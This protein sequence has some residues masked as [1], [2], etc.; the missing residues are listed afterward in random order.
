V[1]RHRLG[2]L[3]ARGVGKPAL[4]DALATGGLALF[5]WE[6]LRAAHHQR[7]VFDEGVYLLKGLLFARH[8]YTPFQPNGPWT[9]H[10]PL[11]FL[12]PGYLQKWLGPGLTTGRYTTIVM[13]VLVLTGMWWLVRQIA[14][15][16]WAA[17]AV[18]AVVVMPAAARVYSMA[19]SEALAAMF[20]IWAVALL[21]TPQ[22]SRWRL[23]ISGLLAGILTMT[24]V[25]M[26]AAWLVLGL[27]AIWQ[28]RRRSLWFWIPSLVVVLGLH[29]LYWPRIMWLWAR[30]LPDFVPVPAAF[31]PPLHDTAATYR[32]SPAIWARVRAL[33]QAVQAFPLAWAG[34]WVGTTAVFVAQKRNNFHYRFLMMGT[35]L[36]WLLVLL[37]GWASIG[38]SYCVNCLTFYTGFYMP[39]LVAL[40][41]IGL[42][43]PW[44]PERTKEAGLFWL[45]GLIF[46]VSAALVNISIFITTVSRA[47]ASHHWLS[48]RLLALLY[49]PQIHFFPDLPPMDAG[50]VFWGLVLLI[51]S[52]IVVSVMWFLRRPRRLFAPGQKTV[53]LASLVILA[54]LSPL[55]LFSGSWTPYDCS[56]DV[57]AVHEDTAVALAQLLPPGTQVYWASYFGTLLLRTEDIILMPQ[58]LNDDYN[59]RQGGDADAL[60]SWGYWNQALAEQWMRSAD[61]IVTDAM[62][63]ERLPLDYRALGFEPVQTFSFLA[64]CAGDQGK[65]IILKRVP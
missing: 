51:A 64:S 8:I 39:V 45:V 27:F 61:V 22:P 56:Q 11:S 47:F 36:A 29:A 54:L 20:F 9:N 15:R 63:L 44:S 46:F 60:A 48:A 37:H 10:M 7:P 6:A 41:C 5:V 12:I 4:W 13:A 16:Q 65:L 18:W 19:V 28:W 52:L 24:R 31:S 25:N 34:L 3:L 57:L 62:R 2:A 42:W 55:T 14:G 43:T 1:R 17:A 30:W 35:F 26:A 33:W 59:R 58:Q 40:I 38:G 53:W 23:L 49:W 50:R 21:A 32:V